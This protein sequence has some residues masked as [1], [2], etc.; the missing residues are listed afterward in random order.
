MQRLID[1]IN[2]IAFDLD[3][4]LIDSLPDL[5][6]A[7]RQML[8]RFDSPPLTDAQLRAH[9]GDGVDA[10]VERTLKSA[11]GHAP[12]ADTLARAV[13]QFRAIYAERVFDKSRVYDGVRE[14]LETLG[15]FG[16]QLGCITNKPSVFTRPLLQAAGLAETFSFILCADH[17]EDRKPAP[18][19][20]Q[21]ACKSLHLEPADMLLVGDSHADFLAARAAGCGIAWVNYGYGSLPAD[22]VPDWTIGSLTEITSLTAGALPAPAAN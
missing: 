21:R 14:A 22:V 2:A 1:S 7:A 20:L 3:G 4:T 5:V 13:R 12:D 16:L 18:N 11:T 17:L 9:I 15:D 6:Q 19:L 8:V 10:L